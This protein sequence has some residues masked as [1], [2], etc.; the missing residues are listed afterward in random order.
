M[1]VGSRNRRSAIEATSVMSEDH[2]WNRSETAGANAGLRRPAAGTTEP[3]RQAVDARRAG[4]KG[5]TQ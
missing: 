2:A 5:G 4:D 3:T 1:E